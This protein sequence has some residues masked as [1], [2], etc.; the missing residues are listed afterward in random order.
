MTTK[1]ERAALRARWHALQRKRIPHPHDKEPRPCEWCGQVYTPKAIRQRGCCPE[2]ANEINC[3]TRNLQRTER[4][5]MD[6]QIKRAAV[7][8]VTVVAAPLVKQDRPAPRACALC[9]FR[10]KLGVHACTHPRLWHERYSRE[11]AYVARAAGHCP[12]GRE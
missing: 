7:K 1:E 2:H 6:L 3:L 9:P 10:A 4:Y 11:P 8:R 5:H 12:L